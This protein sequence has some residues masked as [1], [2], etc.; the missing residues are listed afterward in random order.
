MKLFIALLLGL[1]STAVGAEEAKTELIPLE[2]FSRSAQ[3][4]SLKLSPDGA[5]L[6]AMT[7]K[8]GKDVLIILDTENFKVHHGVSFP[9]NAQVGNY[10]WVNNERVV[11][12]KEYLRGW[13]DHPRYGPSAKA[14]TRGQVEKDDRGER[15]D[16]QVD[17]EV[18]RYVAVEVQGGN[19]QQNGLR[20]TEG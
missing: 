4:H 7:K 2:H 10:Q 6:G 8:E 16:L 13:K 12:S 18:G 19:R 9:S 3:Y 20:K 1:V 15:G 5:Y 14:T 17:G 11:L